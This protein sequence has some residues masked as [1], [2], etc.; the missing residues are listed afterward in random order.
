MLFYFSPCR[1][2]VFDTPL[3]QKTMNLEM[4]KNRIKE[5][6]TEVK[7]SGTESQ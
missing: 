5:Y 3:D 6:Y 4:R 1:T 7:S 2:F